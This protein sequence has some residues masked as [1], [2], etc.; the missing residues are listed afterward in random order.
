MTG[1]FPWSFKGRFWF[2]YTLDR[3]ETLGIGDLMTSLKSDTPQ[4]SIVERNGIKIWTLRV[5][6]RSEESCGGVS[7]KKGEV[8][9]EVNLTRISETVRRREKRYSDLDPPGVKG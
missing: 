3:P 4:R 9:V 7:E 2:F 8:R 5:K 1:H 6:R